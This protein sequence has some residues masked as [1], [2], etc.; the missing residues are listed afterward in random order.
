MSFLIFSGSFQ[1]LF[2]VMGLSFF[3]RKDNELKKISRKQII[4]KITLILGIFLACVWQKCENY[5]F[6]ADTHY[7]CTALTSILEIVVTIFNSSKMVTVKQNVEIIDL[8]F[9]V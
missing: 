9:P 5:G 7:F 6:F 1:I 3:N 4:Y 2:N 8:I